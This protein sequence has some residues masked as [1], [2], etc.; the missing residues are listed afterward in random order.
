MTAGIGVAGEFGEGAGT[1]VICV[2][3]A[4][5][6][7]LAD[8]T[9]RD[10]FLPDPGG[11]TGRSWALQGLSNPEGGTMARLTILATNALLP[12]TYAGRSP[13]RDHNGA[14]SLRNC[15]SKRDAL[16]MSCF[17]RTNIEV[18]WNIGNR[19]KESFTLRNAEIPLMD[20]T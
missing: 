14:V 11:Y 18:M 19:C 10:A 8:G 15:K 2:E 13:S 20:I 4:G 7:P 17:R 6:A 16:E 12:E 1:L 3:G 9:D 5:H